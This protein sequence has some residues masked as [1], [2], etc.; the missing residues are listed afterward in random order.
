GHL[1]RRH[2]RCVCVFELN[3]N[4]FMDSW[5]DRLGMQH[6]WSKVGDLGRF[7]IRDAVENSGIRYNSWV[8]RHDA[9]NVGPDL[10]FVSLDLTPDDRSRIIRA[11]AS[12][13]CGNVRRRRTNKAGNHGHDTRLDHLRKLLAALSGFVEVDEAEFGIFTGD[14]DLPSIDRF[15]FQSQF[16]QV[17]GKDRNNEPFSK[18]TDQIARTGAH[19]A[20]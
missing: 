16:P 6:L 3:P 20:L 17:P 11:S 14:D 1:V 2:F 8:R 9:V 13:S 10:D 18:R 12:K 5:Y 19:L 4:V 7:L 15:R